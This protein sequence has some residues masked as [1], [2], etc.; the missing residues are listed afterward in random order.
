MKKSIAMA[1]ETNVSRFARP[2]GTGY[3]S[4]GMIQ[5]HS[6]NSIEYRDSQIQFRNLEH[7]HWVVEASGYGASRSGTWQTVCRQIGSAIQRLFGFR[8]LWLQR[9]ERSNRFA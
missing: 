5:R 4:H 1:G 3:M 7:G 2:G 9:F 6:V 8:W